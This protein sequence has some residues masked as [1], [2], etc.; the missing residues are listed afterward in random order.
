MSTFFILVLFFDIGVFLW[1]FRGEMKMLTII[2]SLNN[3]IILAKSEDTNEELILFGTGIG[4]KKKKGDLIDAS[5][6]TKVFQPKGHLPSSQLLEHI[7]PAVLT[8]TEKIVSM[9]ED[10][11]NTKLNQ[12]VLLSLADHIQFAIDKE[13]EVNKNNPLQWEVPYLYYVEHEI[14]KRALD[15][16]EEELGHTLPEMES[17]FIALHFVNAQLDS[18]SMEDTIQITKLI[19]NIIKIIQ[20][21]FEINLD[22]TTI[23]YS[24]FITHLRY[25]IA[26]H[27]ISSREV[28]QMDEELKSI[29]QDRY[30]KSYACGLIIK[31]MIEKEFQWRVTEDEVV[32]LVIHIERL[33][34]E[35]K[36]SKN[37]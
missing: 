36:A 5:K 25:F 16:I 12:S 9:G 11:L 14:G 2:K 17:S 33:T 6:A 20:R 32:Y 26:R 35:N 8:V 31:D 3:N 19:K 1:I 7:S 30:M 37:E 13:D 22:K 34:N 29:I 24:R 28:S 23:T 18:D 15:I 27:N 4:F 21:L 10:K